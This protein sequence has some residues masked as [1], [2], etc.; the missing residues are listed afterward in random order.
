MKL[1]GAFKILIKHDKSRE[2]IP[3]FTIS[4][5]SVSLSLKGCQGLYRIYKGISLI[6]HQIA[7]PVIRFVRGVAGVFINGS[8]VPFL[9]P[10]R[11]SCS[12]LRQQTKPGLSGWSENLTLL[13]CLAF[14]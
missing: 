9:L 2:R 12:T 1:N 4:L 5:V 11:L 7:N 8:S 10:V 14:K 13:G 6:T 3:A